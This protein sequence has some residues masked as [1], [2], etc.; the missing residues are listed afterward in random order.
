MAHTSL[1]ALPFIENTIS[2]IEFEN[3]ELPVETTEEVN[4]YL[5]NMSMLGNKYRV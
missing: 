3:M 1:S 4:E 5:N 2:D